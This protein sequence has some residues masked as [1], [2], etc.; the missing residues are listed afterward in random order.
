[1]PGFAQSAHGRRILTA[2]AAVWHETLQRAPPPSPGA[3]LVWASE[4]LAATAAERTDEIGDLCMDLAQALGKIA[5]AEEPPPASP[6]P[7]P[8]PAAA[9]F[10]AAVQ[11]AAAAAAAA[12]RD[13][14]V[15]ELLQAPAGLLA[16]DS[17]CRS[18]WAASRRVRVWPRPG[19]ADIP[20]PLAG[21]AAAA[22]LFGPSIAPRKRPR[23]GGG[24]AG[25]TLPEY[26]MVAPLGGAG[27][28]GGCGLGGWGR[29]G[30]GPGRRPQTW[31]GLF[32]SLPACL[33]ACPHAC[34][35]ACMHA[36]HCTLKTDSAHESWRPPTPGHAAAACELSHSLA[37]PEQS[38]PPPAP[39]NPAAALATLA[40]APAAA[41]AAG[42]DLA[43]PASPRRAAAVPEVVAHKRAHTLM[44]V[45]LRDGKV[46]LGRHVDKFEAAAQQARS[47]GSGSGRGGRGGGAA[48]GAAGSGRGPLVGGAIRLQAAQQGAPLPAPTPAPV[49]LHYQQGQQQQQQGQQQQQQQG[50]QQQ[51]QQPRSRS[52]GPV[53]GPA[54]PR[55][56]D[57]EED[58]AA[59]LARLADDDFAGGVG[60]DGGPAPRLLGSAGSRLPARRM[61]SEGGADEDIYTGGRGPRLTFLARAWPAMLRA[62]GCPWLRGSPAQERSAH[63]EPASGVV[64][65]LRAA[66]PCQRAASAPTALHETARGAAVRGAG[67]GAQGAG[68]PGIICGERPGPGARQARGARPLIQA[69]PP[70]PRG[71]TL[72][73]SQEEHAQLPG[74]GGRLTGRR[75]RTPCALP[76]HALCAPS[77]P[78]QPL[79][80]RRPR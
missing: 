19:K 29:R 52:S 25:A 23:R 48:A 63:L 60:D 7:P 56:E 46:S 72:V 61:S 51:Q 74:A 16:C 38:T 55:Q 37:G 27:R 57:W 54:P 33:P 13:D 77:R 44:G 73:N 71:L 50:Q 32:A 42:A 70:S 20:A 28:L 3:G 58:D 64:Q 34:M 36:G 22:A 30:N 4:R 80:G 43:L 12:P 59:L 41:P 11:A 53:A 8:P 69:A 14:G 39:P 26:R 2:A 6:P 31:R 24:T 1:V 68:P 45:V 5:A 47:G 62:W 79:G 10:A 35:H 75:H 49:A 65:R 40:P 66:P 67:L 18:F 15:D 76:A 21:G 78:V 9:R 17:T